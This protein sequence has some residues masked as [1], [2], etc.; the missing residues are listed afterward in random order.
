MSRITK[1]LLIFGCVILLL[2]LFSVAQFFMKHPH[3]LRIGSKNFTEQIILGEILAQCIENRLNIPVDRKFNLGGTFICFTALKAG[4]LDLYIEYTGTGLTSILNKKAVSNPDKVY[5]IVKDEFKKKWN[6]IWLT[7]LGFNNT[8]TVT[9]RR[10]H[11]KDLGITKISDLE[12][13]TQTLLPGFNHEFLERP[14]GYPGLKDHY[15][16]QFEEE[17]LEMDTGLMYKAIADKKVDIICGFSTDGRIPA[18]DLITLEDD[19]NF[20]PPYW[21]V[22]LIRGEI[23]KNEPELITLI[24]KLSDRISNT[25]MAQMNYLVDEKG[26]SPAYVAQSFLE[27]EG[28]IAHTKPY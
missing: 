15:G 22:P 8:Y 18:F 25:E 12:Q 10:T 6:L 7:P 14:D 11:A 5:K 27:S 20:F 26:E 16:F 19:K 17:P 13:H 1:T 21:P 23:A 3:T 28:L 4:E 2:I 24:H 9:M